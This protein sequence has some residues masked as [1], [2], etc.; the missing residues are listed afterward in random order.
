MYLGFYV[1]IANAT[2]F[3]TNTTEPNKVAHTPNCTTTFWL[4]IPMQFP[5]SVLWWSC[6]KMHLLQA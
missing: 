5:N 6:L 1:H 3:T 2:M 4:C